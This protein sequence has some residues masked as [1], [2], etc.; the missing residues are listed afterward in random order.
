MTET[1]LSLYTSTARIS[2]ARV[3]G[4]YSTSFG[5]ASRLLSRRVRSGIADAYALV[6]IADEIVD[7]PAAEAGMS[8]HERRVVL[9]ALETETVA[10]MRT[11][12]SA[13]LVVHAFAVTAREA[14]IG[15]EL[16]MPF[17]ASMRTDIDPPARFDRESYRRY[18]YGSAEVIGSMCLRVFLLENEDASLD[19]ELEDAARRLGAAFQKVNF[20][21][22]LAQDCDVLGRSYLPGVDPASFTDEDRDAVVEEITADLLAARGAIARLPPRAQRATGLAADLFS[23]LNDRLSHTPAA[24]IRRRR[25]SLPRSVKMRIMLRSLTRR[26]RR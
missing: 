1:G 22:D 23:E 24:V 2:S 8:A 3:I 14:G 19:A 20:L 18:I 9:D 10:A 12:F 4:A 13:N 26:P 15:T 7:G 21:R 5:L 6:R 17:F 16:V 11:G 25:V